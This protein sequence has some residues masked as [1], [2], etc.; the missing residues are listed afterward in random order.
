M[1]AD[2]LKA[3]EAEVYSYVGRQVS[4]RTPA[5]DPVNQAMIRHWTEVMGDKNPAYGD[6][7]WAAGSARG[8][9]IAPPAMMYVWGQDGYKISVEGRA[10]D[11]QVDLVNF[12]NENGYTGVLGTNVR[13][14]YFKESVPG[15]TLF[16][17]MIID[18]I[19]ERKTTAR[20]VGYFI[21]SLATF[22]DQHGD[23]VGTQRFKILKFIPAEDTAAAP[24]EESLAV[25]TRIA[26]PRGHDNGWWWEAC[27]KGKLLIQRCKG[28]QTL[29]HPPRP[30]CGECQS[31]EWDSIESGMRGEVLSHT[32]LHHPRIPGYQYPLVCAVIRLEEG[33]H[34]VANVVGCD[35]S[36]VS[37][38]M[39]VQGRIEQVDEKTMLP[40]FY[41]A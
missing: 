13:Q 17:E 2:E 14:E 29:R 1:N 25:P 33:I 5:N 16:V 32:E 10:S 22:T 40:Q 39:Q 27:D 20:G 15:D 12:F 26:S 4:E 23:K 41:P 7:A 34:F 35:P 19:S 37:I 30:M 38:G 11:A 24:A 36:E 8:H 3:F 9:T 28:C 18:N 31:L 6:Q 21:E